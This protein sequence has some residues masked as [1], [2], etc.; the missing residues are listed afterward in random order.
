MFFL[1]E[2]LATTSD[3][4]FDIFFEKEKLDTRSVVT[5]IVNV[6][7][8]NSLASKKIEV[9]QRQRVLPL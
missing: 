1:E 6:R 7:L 2:S 4:D 8:L 9:Q 3:G 5:R